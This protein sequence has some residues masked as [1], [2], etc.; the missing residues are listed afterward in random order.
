MPYLNLTSEIPLE[1]RLAALF[2]P[3]LVSA[4]VL[5]AMLIYPLYCLS[6]KNYW[7]VPVSAGIAVFL[8]QLSAITGEET[9][10]FTRLLLVSELVC[11]TAMVPYLMRLFLTLRA[12]SKTKLNRA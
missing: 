2:I 7:I 1:L 3:G 5:S 6:E 10:S 9:R 4:L 8:T 11:L 12:F